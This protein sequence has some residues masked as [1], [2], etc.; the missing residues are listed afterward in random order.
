MALYK[1][2]LDETL[3]Q[4]HRLCKQITALIAGEDLDCFPNGNYLFLTCLVSLC[5]L[6][7]CNFAPL[8]QINEEFLICAESILCILKVLFGL[9]KLC[10]SIGQLCAFLFNS[11]ICSCY[12]SLF[13]C[14]QTLICDLS[15]Q[16]LIL[17]GSK[18]SIELMLHCVEHTKYLTT[19]RVVRFRTSSCTST[20]YCFGFL[21][22]S[23]NCAR[24]WKKRT[25]RASKFAKQIPEIFLHYI[26][27]FEE[28]RCPLDDFVNTLQLQEH[29]RLW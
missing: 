29:L 13:G 19:S 28:L 22:K 16:F 17:G 9:C 12:L 23:C 1:T 11:T 26:L 6:L 3:L 27:E 21:L 7:I 8:L 25:R 2:D 4:A 18:V 24:T 14:S 15:L 10:P 20:F 5:I